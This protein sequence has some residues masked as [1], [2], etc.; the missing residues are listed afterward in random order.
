VYTDDAGTKPSDHVRRRCFNCCTTETATWRRSNLNRGKMLC[1]KCGLFER[2][3]SRPRPE[4]PV[5]ERAHSR[6]LP[7][8]SPQA[9]GPVAPSTSR[10]VRLSLSVR[11]VTVVRVASCF[12]SIYSFLLLL[13]LRS[14]LLTSLVETATPTPTALI[15]PALPAC[16]QRVRP[17]AAA[18]AS[19]ADL[20]PG[21]S[22]PFRFGREYAYFQRCPDF[23]A[24]RRWERGHAESP[25]R[26]WKYAMSRDD[27]NWC[28]HRL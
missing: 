24:E 9:R 27:Y 17:A 12:L 5:L 15:S 3:H 1:N 10:S 19:R 8:K 26:E 16:R 20:R 21:W 4:K 18:S 2:T 11:A 6:S 23:L 7:D 22:W 28:Q 14:L 13:I 25:S